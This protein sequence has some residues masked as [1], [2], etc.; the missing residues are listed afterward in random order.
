MAAAGRG[1][2]DANRSPARPVR[3][4]FTGSVYYAQRDSIQRMCDVINGMPSESVRFDIYTHTPRSGLCL[5]GIDTPRVRV[6]HCARDQVPAIQTSAD[7]LFLPLSF[8]SRSP[9]VVRTALPA[10]YVEYLASGV[11]ILVH[12]PAWSWTARLARAQGFAL[13]ADEEDESALRSSLDTIIR[14]GPL[15]ERLVARA[16]ATVRDHDRIPVCR[17]LL[18]ALEAG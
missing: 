6:S 8:H 1:G 16:C 12:A 15:R 11:P 3:I 5:Q 4:V 17:E 13:V 14:D 18:D 10:K 9:D 2:T 7:V